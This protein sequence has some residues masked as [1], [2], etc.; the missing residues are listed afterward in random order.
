MG[1][2]PVGTDAAFYGYGMRVNQTGPANTPQIGTVSPR[3]QW[4]LATDAVT[5]VAAGL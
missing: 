3:G 5:V 1:R 4:R 2:P